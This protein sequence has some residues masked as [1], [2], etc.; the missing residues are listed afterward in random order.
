MTDKKEAIVLMHG[1]IEVQ[2]TKNLFF[3]RGEESLKI[4]KITALKKTWFTYFN[5]I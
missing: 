1:G 4:K 3:W 5:G 2:R